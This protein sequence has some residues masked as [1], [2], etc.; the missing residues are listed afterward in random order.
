MLVRVTVNCAVW[1]TMM[2]GVV[3]EIAMEGGVDDPETLRLPLALTVVPVTAAVIVLL[4]AA[5]PVASPVVLPTVTTAA[6]DEVQVERP[7]R[8]ALSPPV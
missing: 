6:F 4:P 5:T 2:L 1:P 8:S 3:V 7:V